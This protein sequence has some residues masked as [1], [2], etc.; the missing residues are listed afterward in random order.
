MSPLRDQ[1]SQK[2]ANTLFNSLLSYKPERRAC[3]AHGAA[4]HHVIG[5]RLR[6]MTVY[7]D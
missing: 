6:L 4:D 5:A 3:F 1:K 2:S 7:P